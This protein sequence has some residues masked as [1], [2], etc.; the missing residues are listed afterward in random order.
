MIS[1]L[2]TAKNSYKFDPFG[3]VAI[4]VLELSPD[5][6]RIEAD[7]LSVGFATGT[8]SQYQYML[9][10]ADHDWSK[11]AKQRTVTFANLSPGAYKFLVR[12]S[13]PKVLCRG[14]CQF[15]F[16]S[17]AAGVEAMVVFVAYCPG[18]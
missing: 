15:Q 13:I 18:G 5:D 10:G 16:P 3:A 6:N 8:E 17:V 11:P 12:L 4:P 1:D 14:A 9:E 2:R 7:F